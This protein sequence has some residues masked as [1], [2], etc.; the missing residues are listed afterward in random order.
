MLR[1]VSSRVP[2][3]HEERT[4]RP[5]CNSFGLSASVEQSPSPRLFLAATT[6]HDTRSDAM[7]HPLLITN[8]QSLP[9]TA[10]QGGPKMG[11]KE[12]IL[13]RIW[14]RERDL[15]VKG[16]GALSVCIVASGVCSFYTYRCGA[17][18]GAMCAPSP[19]NVL[20]DRGTPPYLYPTHQPIAPHTHASF[21]KRFLL[22]HLL[23]N[24]P[25][26]RIADCQA[27]D[28]VKVTG[29]VRD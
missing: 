5:S 13:E 1:L 14:G 18:C 15:R 28:Y 6:Q 19:I 12:K 9:P 29:Q 22:S 7:L 20:E 17:A 4:A 27:G 21:I 24:V 2:L 26:K 11:I 25:K 8:P 3:T 10:K 16:W 23:R